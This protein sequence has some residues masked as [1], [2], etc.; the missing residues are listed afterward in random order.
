MW[1]VKSH[2][3]KQINFHSLIR[4]GL[5]IKN[6][7]KMCTILKNHSYVITVCTYKLIMQMIL[8]LY[9]FKFLTKMFYLV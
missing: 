5:I 2:G 4:Q 9:E 6:Y 8:N 3:I 1:S 7:N